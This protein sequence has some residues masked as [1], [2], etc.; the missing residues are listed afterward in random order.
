MKKFL[1]YFNL[2]WPDLIAMCV[3]IY[4]FF[5]YLF[6]GKIYEV[7]FGEMVVIMIVSVCNC[8]L[9][10]WADKRKDKYLSKHLDKY[11]ED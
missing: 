9:V 2:V 8:A 3:A 11:E 7:S 1:E 4:I 5:E 6:T 10:V